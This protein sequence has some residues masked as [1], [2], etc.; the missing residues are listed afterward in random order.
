M[1][2][3]RGRRSAHIL[4]EESAEDSDEQLPDVEGADDDEDGE[5][6]SGA[7]SDDSKDGNDSSEGASVNDDT[8]AEDIDSSSLPQTAVCTLFRKRCATVQTY[9]G[10]MLS[11]FN[12]KWWKGVEIGQAA[13][14]GQ[15]AV[16]KM[17]KRQRKRP[18]I[19]P[20]AVFIMV[21]PDGNCRMMRSQGLLQNS[22]TARALTNLGAA[23]DLMVRQQQLDRAMARGTAAQQ[24]AVAPRLVETTARHRAPAGKSEPSSRPLP[25]SEQKRR[26]AR[27]IFTEHVAKLQ[28]DHCGGRNWKN[29]RADDCAC[30]QKCI[31]LRSRLSWPPD[32]PC[33]NPNKKD[34][35]VDTAWLD[36]FLEWARS[37][38]W[39]PQQEEERQQQAMTRYGRVHA[40]FC[41]VC[42]RK[43]IWWDLTWQ[44]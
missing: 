41:K 36:K 8:E 11:K 7:G 44:S 13:S 17:R 3:T 22:A 35:T 20:Q 40:K 37:K 6:L 4:Y 42:T 15:E 30:Q 34:T 19:E 1:T 12:R 27:Q 28:L 33:V 32:L 39:L 5:S 9:I 18:R 29:C 10:K 25:P 2:T 38:G 31:A 26:S 23:I 21:D 14:S 43:A 16:Q 24:P